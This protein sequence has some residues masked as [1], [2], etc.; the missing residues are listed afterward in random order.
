MTSKYPSGF[1]VEVLKARSAFSNRRKPVA[2]CFH[3]NFL[4]E[5]VN[6]AAFQTGTIAAAAT[7][8]ELLLPTRD[9]PTNNWRQTRTIRE[10]TINGSTPSSSIEPMTWTAFV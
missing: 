9:F 10:R 2:S 7:S 8:F 6:S 4:Q 1:G 3:S 5:V